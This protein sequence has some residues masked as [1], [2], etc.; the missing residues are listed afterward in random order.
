MSVQNLVDMVMNVS[1]LINELEKSG[2]R[3][4]IGDNFSTYRSYRI[5][6]T[7]RPKM[8]PMFDVSASYVDDSNGFWLCGF[9][10]ANELIHTQ[11]VRLLDLSGKSL[12]EH[13]DLH[14]HKYITPDTTPDPDLTFYEGPEAL[15]TV[16]G[17]VAYHGEFWL[18]AL[19][20][21]GPRISLQ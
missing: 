9:N 7:D 18:T 19:G 1:G 10:D 14:R 16:T 15:K 20:L 21:G 11:A 4:V 12:K 2:I 3:V 13:L 5:Q 8:Y 6:Q 17:K